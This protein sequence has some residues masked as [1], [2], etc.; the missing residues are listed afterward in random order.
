M[1]IIFRKN[2]TKNGVSTENVKAR[3]LKTM[4]SYFLFPELRLTPM[5][6][7]IPRATAD[8]AKAS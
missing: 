2:W 6:M 1:F 3:S 7:P 4:E 8:M 5:S